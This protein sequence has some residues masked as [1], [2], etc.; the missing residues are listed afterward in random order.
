MRLNECGGIICSVREITKQTEEIG[1]AM[2]AIQSTPVT[3]A[4]ILN[5]NPQTESKIIIPGHFGKE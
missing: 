1:L 3:K 4:I 2:V 5:T